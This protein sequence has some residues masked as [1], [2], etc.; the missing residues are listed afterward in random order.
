MPAKVV[1]KILEFKQTDEESL[2][3]NDQNLTNILEIPQLSRTINNNN[4]IT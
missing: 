3:L 2:N 1:K 4:N